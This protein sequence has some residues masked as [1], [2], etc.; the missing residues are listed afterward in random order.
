MCREKTE[1]TRA[2]DLKGMVHFKHSFD[3]NVQNMYPS[4]R[5]AFL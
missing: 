2:V 1:D 5:I 3:L 4:P